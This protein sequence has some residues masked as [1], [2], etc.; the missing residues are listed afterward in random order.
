[1]TVSRGFAHAT[2]VCPLPELN[3]APAFVFGEKK[4]GVQGTARKKN[5]GKEQS[6]SA[7]FAPALLFISR[8]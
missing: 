5:R 8:A 7:L 3:L 4:I 1:L 6:P 2:G